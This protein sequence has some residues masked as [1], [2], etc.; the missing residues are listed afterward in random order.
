MTRSLRKLVKWSY[1][2]IALALILLAVLVQSGRSFS[3]L[4]DSHTQDIAAY[5]ST[6]LNA[7][8]V[9]GQMQADWNGLKPSLVIQ[10]FSIKSQAGQPI[11]A[12]KQA[13]LRLDI[14][15]SLLNL[16]L[17]W[18]NL[19]LNQVEMTFAQTDEGFWRIPGMPE[20][21]ERDKPGANLDALLYMLL[22]STKIE[23]QSSHLSFH[24][25]SGK[26]VVMDSPF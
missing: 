6:K 22:L 14:L 1:L 16:R 9:I 26:Q 25:T 7:P 2:L 19:S 20:R 15:K 4:L 5:L 21:A 10:D 11:V 12:L 13:R 18:S 17:V 8:V 23:F 3:H 24:F